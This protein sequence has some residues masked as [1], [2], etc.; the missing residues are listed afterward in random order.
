MR[1]V[2]ARLIIFVACLAAAALSAAGAGVAVVQGTASAPNDA[3]RNYSRRMAAQIARWLTD[4]GVPNTIMD[5]EAVMAGGLRGVRLAVLSYNPN[6]P[7]RELREVSAFARAGG[8]LLVFYSADERLAALL[9]VQLGEYRAEQVVGQWSSF[10]FLAGG[11]PNLPPRVYQESHNIRPA[12]PADRSA[13]VIAYWENSAGQLSRDPAWTLSP[14]GAWMSHV[15]LDGDSPNKQLMLLGLL[16]FFDP[17]LWQ[18]AAARCANSAAPIGSF[19]GLNDAFALISQASRGHPREADIL[20]RLG[21]ARQIAYDLQTSYTQG[22]YP[23][24]VLRRAELAAT[25]LQA[26]G[27]AQYPRV[28]ELR[29]VWNHSGT[30]LYPGDWDR[31]CRVLADRGFNAVFPNM[32]WAGVAHYESRVVPRSAIVARYG[33]QVAQ[34]ATAAHRYGLQMHV[35]KVCWNLEGAPAD[36]VRQLRSEQR[37]QITDEGETLP[38]MCPSQPANVAQELAALREVAGRYDID[39]IHLDYI[40]FPSSHA[41][42]C[43]A[44]RAAFEAAVGRRIHGWP[45]EVR[46]GAPALEYRAWRCRQITSFVRQARAEVNRLKP[47]ARVSAAVYGK[48]PSCADSMG[49]DWPAWLQEGLVDFV[50]PMD[51]F[52]DTKQFE[53]YV[54]TQLAMPSAAGRIVPGIGVTSTSTRL[55]AVQTINQIV[56]A[57]AAGAPGFILFE[58]NPTLDREIFP[59]LS[60]GVTAK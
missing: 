53:D 28:H 1:P 20:E 9:H 7:S 24:V 4:A 26:Y 42:Y 13:C 14:S 58:L 45:A 54:R 40:R 21:A 46:S 2:A 41:C 43:S 37:L 27:L 8:R 15:L 29:A 22:Q 11:P 39:G 60:L 52:A 6:L 16:A 23:R 17:S 59:V 38:W 19:S 56:R 36:Y 44:C 3:E 30:G 25:L 57:R 47:Q 12:M 49:Q 35:W 48:Y 32:L 31:T 34:C 51:Y 18:A 55:D 10:A 50:C 5:D 33:D